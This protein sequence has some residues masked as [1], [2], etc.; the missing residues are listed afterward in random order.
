MSPSNLPNSREYLLTQGAVAAHERDLQANQQFEQR[1]AEARERYGN[2]FEYLHEGKK[3]VA[4]RQNCDVE[5]AR[6]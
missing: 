4:P 5:Y 1:V 6:S 3:H 2:V